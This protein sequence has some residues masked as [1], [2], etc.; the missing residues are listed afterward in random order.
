MLYTARQGGGAFCNGKR[1]Q[2]SPPHS[3]PQE[4]TGPKNTGR[5]KSACL[6]PKKV[7][8]LADAAVRNAKPRAKAHKLADGDGLSL[9]ILPTGERPYAAGAP[10]VRPVVR[11]LV[12]WRCRRAVSRVDARPPRERN[13]PGLRRRAAPTLRTAIPGRSG[14][15]T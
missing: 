12:A 9:E 4:L 14:S 7:R 5:S 1:V 10:C 2:V 13:A 11:R 6:M 15:G 3:R 8:P